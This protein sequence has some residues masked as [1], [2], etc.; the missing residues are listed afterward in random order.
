MSQE[1]IWYLHLL[2]LQCAI[3]YALITTK[4]V[5]LLLLIHCYL[6]SPLLPLIFPYAAPTY[7]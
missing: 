2:Y 3:H 4:L 5:L 6:M 7:I 1:Y